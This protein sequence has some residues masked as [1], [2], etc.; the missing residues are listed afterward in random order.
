M[1]SGFSFII[2]IPFRIFYHRGDVKKKLYRRWKVLGNELTK[3]IINL[4]NLI[5]KQ[6]EEDRYMSLA[7][8]ATITKA[9]AELV[10]AKANVLTD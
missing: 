5:N 8:L 3:T 7:D 10:T 9:L 6:V 1:Q 2:N 4:C